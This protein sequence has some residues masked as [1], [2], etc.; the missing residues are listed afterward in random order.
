MVVSMD[1]TMA[2]KRDVM[3]VDPTVVSME[4]SLAIGLVASSAVLMVVMTAL[5]RAAMKVV[6]R[7]ATMVV[8]SD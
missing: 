3:R 6:T 8:K 1:A 5:K 7:V 2:A 4:T